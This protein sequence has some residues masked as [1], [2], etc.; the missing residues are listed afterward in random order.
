MRIVDSHSHPLRLKLGKTEIALECYIHVFFSE[1]CIICHTS[2]STL[3][4][5]AG[6]EPRTVAT[7]AWLSDALTILG[8]IASIPLYPLNPQ[9][10]LRIVFTKKTEIST[11]R[12]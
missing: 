4:E 6:I 7:S 10:L 5:D 12:Q 8:Y 11:R 1:H 9:W 2:D 3:A